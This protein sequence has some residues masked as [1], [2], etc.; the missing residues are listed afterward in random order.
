MIECTTCVH[1]S[2]ISIEKTN[3]KPTFIFISAVPINCYI[4]AKSILGTFCLIS[5]LAQLF[6]RSCREGF[7]RNIATL[8]TAFWTRRDRG[9]PHILRTTVQSRHRDY[10][11]P[12]QAY[13]VCD[14]VSSCVYQSYNSIMVN[15]SC[16]RIPWL[17]INK[18]SQKTYLFKETFT[19]LKMQDRSADETRN[20]Q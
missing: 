19:T 3:Q 8:T 20:Q 10:C 13:M 5:L 1:V 15:L 18:S 9:P 17:I 11:V 6:M 2:V 12:A 4:S 7:D 14:D 16:G